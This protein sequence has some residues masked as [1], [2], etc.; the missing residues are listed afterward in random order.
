MDLAPP[1]AIP[2]VF[3][4]T[5]SQR[6]PRQSRPL[7][8]PGKNQHN[9]DGKHRGKSLRNR[10]PAHKK[11]WTKLFLE[12]L[13]PK[14]RSGWPGVP[15]EPPA[16]ARPGPTSGGNLI[17]SPL[18]PSLWCAL[19]HEITK[20][21]RGK[22]TTN[23]DMASQLHTGA[24]LE[25]PP[26]FAPS[27]ARADRD[28]NLLQ[29]WTKHVEQPKWNFGTQSHLPAVFVAHTGQEKQPSAVGMK[30][31]HREVSQSL[32]LGLRR[33]EAEGRVSLWE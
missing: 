10:I 1:R 7:P 8:R 20:I 12:F 9:R 30:L 3:S 28:G 21:Y 18:A 15:S 13:L 24:S 27:P 25:L 31:F 23:P 2:A 32:S 16:P 19:K 22:K 33:W 11:C 14:P 26:P 17:H 29:S 5:T 6:R 4:S